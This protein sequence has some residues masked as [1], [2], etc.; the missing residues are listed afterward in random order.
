M[1]AE[2]SGHLFFNDRYFGFDDA[3]YATF[4]VLEL[5]AKGVDMEAELEALP[6]VYNTPELKV[7]TTEEKKFIIIEELKKRLQDANDLPP[8]Q[9]IIDIDGVRIEFEEGWALVRAS[10]TTPVLVTRFEAKT[11]ELAKSYEKALMELLR[12]IMEKI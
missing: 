12:T 5:V 6:K 8:I 4:R 2:V 3:I 7:T 11:P 10:N 9:K 1:A